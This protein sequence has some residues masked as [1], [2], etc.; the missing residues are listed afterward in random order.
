MIAP[1]RH[2]M[3]QLRSFNNCF[4]FFQDELYFEKVTQCI[5][6]N[7]DTIRDWRLFSKHESE[8]RRFVDNPE[9]DFDGTA[10]QNHKEIVTVRSMAFPGNPEISTV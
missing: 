5:E 8:E 3:D 1:Y 7:N 6:L 2:T 10:I 9:H 4:L